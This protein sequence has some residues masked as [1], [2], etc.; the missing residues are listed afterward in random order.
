MRYCIIGCCRIFTCFF[1]IS[2]KSLYIFK[3]H[4]RN[5]LLISLRRTIFEFKEFHACQSHGDMQFCVHM[6]FPLPYRISCVDENSCVD[7]HSGVYQNSCVDEYSCVYKFSCVDVHSGVYQNS[8]VDKYSC[9]DEYSCVYELSC[10][11]KNSC[12]DEY[13]CVYENSCVGKNSLQKCRRKFRC[14]QKFRC[15]Q[16]CR[17]PIR[18]A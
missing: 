18:M 11:D 2:K 16:T 5:I 15:R 9:V 8:C 4:N 17:S 14:I 1:K 3:S 7:L 6:K 10:V 13:S 12:V